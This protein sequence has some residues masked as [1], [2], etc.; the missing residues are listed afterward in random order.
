MTDGSGALA[1]I[2]DVTQ[3]I[4]AYAVDVISGG[5]LVFTPSGAAGQNYDV[6]DYLVSGNKDYQ[7][8]DILAQ[9]ADAGTNYEAC[10]GIAMNDST[11]GTGVGVIRKGIVALQAG[12]TI[13][14]GTLV[15]AGITANES[16]KVEA[17]TAD[18]FTSGATAIVL[19]Q[20][21]TG[22][23]ADTKHLYVALNL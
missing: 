8:T 15:Y 11:S 7:P 12:E 13:E 23:S 9:A 20:A 22:A 10:I 14:P 21:L 4:S 2:N 19:G 3:S 17:V 18:L 16:Y 1:L 5:Q 6:I